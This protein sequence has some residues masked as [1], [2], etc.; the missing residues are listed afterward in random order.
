MQVVGRRVGEVAGL[1]G[2]LVMCLKSSWMV[3]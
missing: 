1:A 2:S 3:C